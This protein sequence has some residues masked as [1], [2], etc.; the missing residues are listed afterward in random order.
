MVV[1]LEGHEVEAG[2]PSGQ[3]R[4]QGR[5]LVVLEVESEPLVDEIAEQAKLLLR[6]IDIVIGGM[7]H[8]PL[9]AEGA[10]EH[11]ERPRRKEKKD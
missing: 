3:A 9:N 11:T 10:E 4:A 6:K 5:L 7:I 8:R 2:E 1:V